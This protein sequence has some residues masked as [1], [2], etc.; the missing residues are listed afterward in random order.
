MKANKSIFERKIV[1]ISLLLLTILS[2]CNSKTNNS[3]NTQNKV[4]KSSKESEQNSE[5]S[6]MTV[7]LNEIFWNA[8]EISGGSFMSQ[9]NIV[10]RFENNSSIS[11]KTIMDSL[12]IGRTYEISEMTPGSSAE[13]S[14]SFMEGENVFSSKK[15]YL[16]FTE[17]SDHAISGHFEG[18]LT[19]FTGKEKKLKDGEFSLKLR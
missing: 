17:K 19:D 3:G 1:S 15:G 9:T 8:T 16:K 11:V 12:E 14:I 2:S 7:H 18:L 5:R 6:Y 13:V 10:G 4:I